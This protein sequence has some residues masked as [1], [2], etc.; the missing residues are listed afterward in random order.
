MIKNLIIYYLFF[1]NCNSNC[2]DHEFGNPIE[3]RI[4]VPILK[5]YRKLTNS[6]GRRREL[7]K[8]NF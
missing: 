3:Y 1:L 7:N 5:K 8:N 4:Q 2:K 6:R